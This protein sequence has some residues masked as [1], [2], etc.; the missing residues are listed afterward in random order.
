MVS[1][2]LKICKHHIAITRV[3]S[4]EREMLEKVE[5]NINEWDIAKKNRW[6]GYAQCLMISTGTISLEELKSVVRN[7]IKGG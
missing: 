6:I 3:G 2:E 4:K 1:N 7:I 5:A